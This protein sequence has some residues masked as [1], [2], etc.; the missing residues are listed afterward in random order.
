[1][2]RTSTGHENRSHDESESKGN[3]DDDDDDDGDDDAAAAA[4]GSG[5][6]SGEVEV[7]GLLAD[8]ILKRPESLG[9]KTGSR[10]SGDGTDVVFTFPSLSNLGN[11]ESS[12][13]GDKCD[14]DA[15]QDDQGDDGDA[16]KNDLTLSSP[17]LQDQVNG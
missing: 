1:M 7:S 12:A 3:D 13:K 6:E 16:N 9:A 8:A 17:K 10:A 11:V 2:E 5:D 15:N 14:D 4:S